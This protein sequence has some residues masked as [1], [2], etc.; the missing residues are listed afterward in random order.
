MEAFMLHATLKN[1]KYVEHAV[2]TTQ[3]ATRSR[4]PSHHHQV[5]ISDKITAYCKEPR[6]NQKLWHIAV[7][8]MQKVLRKI[9]KTADGSGTYYN[10]YSR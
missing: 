1:R 8:K 9:F 2:D 5:D 4:H 7:I 3:V 6:K 10:D